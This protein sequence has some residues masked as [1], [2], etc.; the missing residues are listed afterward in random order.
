MVKKRRKVTSKKNVELK[1]NTKEIGL[2]TK[3]AKESS[4]LQNVT[5]IDQ[6]IMTPKFTMQPLKVNYYPATSRPSYS[7]AME[8]DTSNLLLGSSQLGCV[9]RI[10]SQLVSCSQSTTRPS[11]FAEHFLTI[12]RKEYNL[13]NACLREVD[14]ESETLVF[15][16]FKCDRAENEP[17]TFSL[18]KDKNIIVNAIN[19]NLPIIDGDQT[20]NQ[21]NPPANQDGETRDDGSIC[22]YPYTDNIGR[23]WLFTTCAFSRK[24]HF[25]LEFIAVLNMVF[26][27]FC[28]IYNSIAYA[29]AARDYPDFIEIDIHRD[30]RFRA[31][32]SE[33]IDR[34][35]FQNAFLAVARVEES[36]N[37]LDL[38]SYDFALIDGNTG[39]T[40]ADDRCAKEIL[41]KIVRDHPNSSFIVVKKDDKL[42]FEARD[43]MVMSPCS[44]PPTWPTEL[45]I[46]ITPLHLKGEDVA[47]IWLESNNKI[48]S[49]DLVP[50]D[51]GIDG[52]E[53][54]MRSISAERR[55]DRGEVVAA[56][57][58]TEEL[59]EACASSN[60]AVLIIGPKGTGKLFYARLINRLTFGQQS[61]YV[62][63]SPF[64]EP[65]EGGAFNDILKRAGTVVLYHLENFTMKFQIEV[66]RLLDE[67]RISDGS[68]LR[69]KIIVV[70]RNDN[71]ATISADASPS[72]R[73]R[74]KFSCVQITTENI[75]DNL[76]RFRKLVN[77]LLNSPDLLVAGKPASLDNETWTILERYPWPDNLPELRR[78]LKVMWGMSKGASTWTAAFVPIHIKNYFNVKQLDPDY[79]KY[80]WNL[81]DIEGAQKFSRHDAARRAKVDHP[82]ENNSEQ[83]ILEHAIQYALN[84]GSASADDVI[85]RLKLQ[86]GSKPYHYV[87]NKFNK[88]SDP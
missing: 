36:T 80:C 25:S 6:S 26:P 40:H 17:R 65:R 88:K 43:G 39:S 20:Q 87:R 7:T 57:E 68:R 71:A 85:R 55:I 1:P 2:K 12:L 58:M 33:I 60:E 61:P 70:L 49:S 76:P 46:V 56:R 53:A 52:I 14:P 30:S 3:Q 45:R 72:I 54:D 50:M 75:R 73:A 16:E 44:A 32:L 22:S 4:G 21:D 37:E 79:C 86:E 66:L 69:A 47:C 5:S 77:H 15:V 67:G 38:D 8:L 81:L 59:R 78:V 42:H 41:L 29:I 82:N 9:A 27:V 13:T 64:N 35:K 11:K 28:A 18:K 74:L 63:L 23:R 10:I 84:E 19:T 48:T 24:N 34:S 62:E 83:S 51:K 31:R